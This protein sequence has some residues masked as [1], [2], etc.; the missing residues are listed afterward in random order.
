MIGLYSLYDVRGKLWSNPFCSINDATAQRSVQSA[1]TQG[2]WLFTN[3]SDF[4]LYA[5]GSF[6]D[7]EGVV[8]VHNVPVLVCNVDSIVV[9]V[10]ANGGSDNA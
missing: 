6:D 10:I 4:R 1:A 7:S 3:P 8:L 2:T 5:L 9:S